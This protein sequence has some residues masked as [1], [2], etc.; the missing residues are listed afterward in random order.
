[1]VY[2]ALAFGLF[3]FIFCINWIKTA[4]SKKDLFYAIFSMIGSVV[5]FAVGAYG[6]YLSFII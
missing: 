2:F 6:V 1:M 5:M 4:T 3:G